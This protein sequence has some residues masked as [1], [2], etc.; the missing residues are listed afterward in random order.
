MGMSYRNSPRCANLK[1][2]RQCRLCENNHQIVNGYL[3]HRWWSGRGNPESRE[4]KEQ[5][6]VPVDEVVTRLAK[7]IELEMKELRRSR[8]VS[9]AF[10]LGVQWCK[11]IVEGS[12]VMLEST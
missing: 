4:W 2:G 9:D 6:Y 5:I 10:V 3:I 8:K 11:E 7:R 1:F 12:D